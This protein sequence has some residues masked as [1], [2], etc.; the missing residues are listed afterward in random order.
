MED[1]QMSPAMVAM[2]IDRVGVRDLRLP[3][4]IR[5]REKGAQVEVV[6]GVDV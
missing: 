6:Q 4:V 5:D 2:A 3:I 1:V